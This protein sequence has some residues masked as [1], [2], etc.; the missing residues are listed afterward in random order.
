MKEGD[1]SEGEKNPNKGDQ[2]NGKQL[3]VIW[4]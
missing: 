2:I 4:E 1:F 3:L